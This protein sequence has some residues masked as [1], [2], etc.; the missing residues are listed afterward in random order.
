MSVIIDLDLS[1]KRITKQQVN[2]TNPDST[3]SVEEYYKVSVFIPYLDYFINQLEEKF[4]AHSDIFK[5]I[6]NYYIIFNLNL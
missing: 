4:S 5:G 1:T 2:R 3:L 6:L